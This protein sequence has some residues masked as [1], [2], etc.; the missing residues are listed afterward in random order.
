MTGRSV[1]NLL[2]AR[3]HPEGFLARQILKGNRRGRDH[4]LERQHDE[5]VRKRGRMLT[6]NDR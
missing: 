4:V 5:T 3:L 2:G 1:R 6:F